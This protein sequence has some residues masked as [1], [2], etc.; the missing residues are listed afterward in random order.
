MW[1]CPYL[2]VLM[3]SDCSQLS[4]EPGAS[5]W[6]T[7]EGHDLIWLVNKITRYIYTLSVEVMLA[8]VI[9]LLLLNCGH[10]LGPRVYDSST[11][12]DVSCPLKGKINRATH[13]RCLFLETLE[14]SFYF[15]F[16]V[17]DGC[18]S[19]SIVLSQLYLKYDIFDNLSP[20]HLRHELILRM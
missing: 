11:G 15:S 8:P 5:I 17:L 10:P 6:P 12:W 7:A 3:L 16:T 20:V 9:S 13:F 4:I 2:C 19:V 14:L 1:L 18:P